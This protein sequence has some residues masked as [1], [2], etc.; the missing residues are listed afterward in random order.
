GDHLFERTVGGGDTRG[1]ARRRRRRRAT[2]RRR[3]PRRRLPAPPDDSPW[4]RRPALPPSGFRRLCLPPVRRCLTRIGVCQRARVGR[5]YGGRGRLFVRGRR[6]SARHAAA[7]CYPPCCRI[8]FLAPFA[9]AHLPAR[10]VG[11]PPDDVFVARRPCMPTAGFAPTPH[12]HMRCH[13]A[14]A[15]PRR[16][17]TLRRA[18]PTWPR[19]AGAAASGRRSIEATVRIPAPPQADA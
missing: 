14:Y 12:G 4:I 11:P 19:R 17:A 5:F 8:V 16:A 7:V 6:C 9:C 15:R 18:L 1:F 10:W 3:R 2:R 13:A